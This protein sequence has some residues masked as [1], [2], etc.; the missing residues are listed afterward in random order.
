MTIEAQETSVH[1]NVGQVLDVIEDVVSVM[2]WSHERRG[3]ELSTQVPGRWCDYAVQFTWIGQMEFL[4]FFCVLDMR[5]EPNRMKEAYELVGISNDKTLLGSFT[6]S[7]E[8][9]LPLF[10]IVVPMRGQKRV[11][12]EQIKDMLNETLAECERFYPAFQFV[13]WG[14]KNP[15]E[16]IRDAMIEVEG[17]A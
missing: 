8:D 3:D 5:I 14:G 16:A 13:I 7:A 1:P 17:T 10:R 2:E 15:Q 12:P 11:S 9:R 6:I 4:A